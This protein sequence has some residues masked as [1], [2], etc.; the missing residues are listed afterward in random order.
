[1]SFTQQV[2]LGGSCNPTTWRQDTVIPLLEEKGIKFY[3][4]QVEDWRPELM[5][6]EAQAKADSEV[7]LFVIDLQTRAIASIL[8]ATEYG[9]TG[10]NVLIVVDFL[11]D[12]TEI[13]GQV[14]TGRELSDLN[15]A[16]DYLRDLTSR[17]DNIILCS[18]PKLAMGIVIHR[19][20]K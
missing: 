20:A 2:F 11:E 19:F 5:E 16:R 4:P 10:R 7:L 3:N 6:L 12:G 15:R 1:M 8:E 13:D 9:C 14:I 17:H 18:T